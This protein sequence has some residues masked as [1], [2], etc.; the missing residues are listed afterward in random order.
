[1][2]IDASLNSVSTI[3]GNLYQSFYE[4]AV[5]CLEYVRV[6][7]RV[8]TTCSS[9]LTSTLKL[10]PNREMVAQC[11]KN[12]CKVV[13]SGTGPTSHVNLIKRVQGYRMGD[14]G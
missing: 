4:A 9:L 10:F 2:Y 8:R 14:R 3:L 7:S 6:L 5:R 1:M 12:T 11:A 13:Q